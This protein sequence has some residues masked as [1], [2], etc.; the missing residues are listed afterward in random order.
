MTR[1][2]EGDQHESSLFLFLNTID[3]G[4]NDDPDVETTCR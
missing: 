4:I 3:M 2:R 1:V